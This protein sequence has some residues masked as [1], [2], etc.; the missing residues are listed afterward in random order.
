[1]WRGVRRLQPAGCGRKEARR[2]IVKLAARP[3]R[4][5]RRSSR[6]GLGC[7]ATSAA[8]AGT[9]DA[10]AFAADLQLA[11]ALG[12]LFPYPP[13]V[14]AVVRDSGRVVLALQGVAADRVSD[15]GAGR[16][17]DRGAGAAVAASGHGRAEDAAKDRPQHGAAPGGGLL[18]PVADVAL[19]VF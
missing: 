15:R 18:L 14:V 17:A 19:P 4:R 10:V 3:R 8:A 13:A 11:P 9:P 16:A 7:V 12:F 5:E 2:P 1:G 6:S